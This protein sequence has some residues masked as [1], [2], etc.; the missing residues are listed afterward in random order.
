MHLANSIYCY[1]TVPIWGDVS[2]R[3]TQLGDEHAIFDIVTRNKAAFSLTMDWVQHMKGVVD[4]KAFV[5]DMLEASKNNTE[6]NY[7]ICQQDTI[8]GNLTFRVLGQNTMAIGYWL[9]TKWQGQGIMTQCI[10][11]MSAVL[12]AN[13]VCKTLDISMA[14]D[15]SKSERVAINAGYVFTGILKEKEY[16]NGQYKDQKVYIKNKL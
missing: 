5:L 4:I 9:D 13:N 2:V 10:K 8:I 7:A 3:K 6:H 16:L 1:H 11:T 14:V 15:N 12:L